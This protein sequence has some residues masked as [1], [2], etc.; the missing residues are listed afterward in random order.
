MGRAVVADDQVLDVCPRPAARDAAAVRRS[1]R[2]PVVTSLAPV[3]ERLGWPAIRSGIEKRRGVV[4]PSL[5]PDGRHRAGPLS[6]EREPAM[7][8]RNSSTESSG[9]TAQERAA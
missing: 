8:A 2:R 7:P 5:S 9:F 1:S 3:L 4:A 6:I